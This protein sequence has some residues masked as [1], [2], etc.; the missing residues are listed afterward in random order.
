MFR[1]FISFPAHE[2]DIGRACFAS[3]GL[4]R[5]NVELSNVILPLFHTIMVLWKCLPKIKSLVA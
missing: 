5:R 4:L 2:Y 3:I 1:C